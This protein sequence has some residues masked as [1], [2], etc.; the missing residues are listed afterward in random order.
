MPFAENFKLHNGYTHEHAA[1]RTLDICPDR[2]DKAA[3][4]FNEVSEPGSMEHFNQSFRRYIC[5]NGVLGAPC[6]SVPS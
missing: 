6:E 4:G 5:V 2:K 3:M 1:I